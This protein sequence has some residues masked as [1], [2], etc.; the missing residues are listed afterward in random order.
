MYR[1]KNFQRIERKKQKGTKKHNW[2]TKGGYIAPIM[3]PSTPN[4]ELAKALRGVVEQEQ[5]GSLKFKIVET[6]GITIKSRV[7]KSNP[8]S[9]LGCNDRSCVLCKDGKGGGGTAEKRMFNTE[10]TATFAQKTILRFILAR[11]SKNQYKIC[12]G[13]Q[14]KISD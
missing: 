10:W 3:V 8:Y 9:T 1:E 4:G 5:Q 13:G 6:G 12:F 11:Q 2:S 14:H 7:Q